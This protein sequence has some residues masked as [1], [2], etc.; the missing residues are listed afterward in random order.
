MRLKSVGATFRVN[1]DVI[2]GLRY[3]QVVKKAGIKGIQPF[4]HLIEFVLKLLL[5]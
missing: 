1:H 2:S 3:I 5:G 4:L